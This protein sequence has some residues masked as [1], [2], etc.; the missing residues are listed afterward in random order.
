MG[1][2]G[3]SLATLVLFATINTSTI[4]VPFDSNMLPTCIPKYDPP[5]QINNWRELSL[6]NYPTSL[7]NN[8]ELEKIDIIVSFSKNVIENSKDIDSEFVE[9]VNNNFWD[10]I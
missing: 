2:T 1:N 6:N 5:N 9:I 8:I 4:C 10:L 3:T 7:S